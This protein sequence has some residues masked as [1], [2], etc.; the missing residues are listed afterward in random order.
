M[1]IV[2]GRLK[3]RRLTAPPGDAV[4][5]TSDSLRETLFNVLADRV[6]GA[7]VLDAFAGT[8]ALG[9]EALSRGAAHATFIE[10]DRRVIRVLRENVARCGAEDACT[11]I[12]ADF[13]TVDEPAAFDL[14]LLDPPYGTDDVTTVLERAAKFV[15]S[16]GRLVLEHSRRRDSPSAVGTFR[17]YRVLQAGDSA[18]SFYS[19]P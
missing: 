9:L 19:T 13:T 1:R 4:R 11:I 2:A 8:G 17:R 7:R 6:D 15:A 3:G 12:G 16:E 5:P 18:L 10:R 14:V